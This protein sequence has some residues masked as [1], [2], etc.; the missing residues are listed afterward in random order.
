MRIQPIR[1]ET[2]YETAVARIRKLMGA[3]PGTEAADELEILATLV[4]AYEVR[5]FPI[6]APHPRA[7]LLFVLEQQGLTRKDLEPMIGSRARV[8][9]ILSGKRELTL[10]MIRR[11]SAGLRIPAD[12]L[13][14]VEAKPKRRKAAAGRKRPSAEQPPPRLAAAR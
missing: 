5:K 13:V 8:S 9:E 11:L 6:K 14:G 7:I 4:D 10:P 3:E 12:L 1:T 2:D